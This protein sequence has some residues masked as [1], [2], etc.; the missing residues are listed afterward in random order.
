MD[1]FSRFFLFLGLFALL[2]FGFTKFSG[3]G[4]PAIQ[5]I[6]RAPLVLPSG[7][8][9]PEAT[10][11][12]WSDEYR[13]V[14]SSRG[15]VVKSLVPLVAK[16]RKGGSTLDLVTTPD[17]P[18][19]SP[20]FASFRSLKDPNPTNSSLVETDLQDFSIEETTATR[21]V[22]VHRS[23]AAEIRKTFSVGSGPYG[24]DLEVQLKNLATEPKSYAF[25]LSTSTYRKNADVQNGM[26][27]QNP[28]MTKVECFGKDGSAVREGPDAF[29]PDDFKDAEKFRGLDL[30][31]GDHRT[32]PGEASLAAISSAY[33]TT[34]MAPLVSP[35]EATCLLQIE[36]RWN[37]A[38][39]P[40]KGKDPNAAAIYRA[41]LAYSPKTLAPGAVDT[42]R[43]HAYIGPKERRALAESGDRF[44]ALIDLGFFSSVA[45]LLVS[46]LLFLYSVVKNWGLAIVLLTISAKLLLFP[47]TLP[48]LKNMIAMRELKPEMDKL[49]ERYKDDAQA[50]GLAQM[51]LWKKH[52]VNPM[53]GCWPQ[54]ASM[55]VWFAL[56]TTLQTA[57]ELYN[58]PFLWFPDLS[59]SDP[60]YILPFVIGGVFFLQQK[61][62]PMQGG[63][64][65]QQK[66]MMYM[67]PGMFTV[68]MLF[69]PAGLGVYMLT[70]SLLGI[71]Q[72]QV[73]EAHA[74][75]TLEAKKNQVEVL[76][77]PRSKKSV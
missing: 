26:F 51:E 32:F 13:A 24:I 6:R 61:L 49:N 54:L 68:F 5:P 27:R 35:T 42:F 28:M 66:M 75:K 67:M 65:A 34:A 30:H 31:V 59:E 47:L 76:G 33:F 72:Q 77:A 2:Y 18:E 15:G 12:L 41:R 7:E 57:V 14:L 22:F 25:S 62:T 63:D 39:F 73:V 1:R 29:E 36:E 40:D 64:P 71:V 11:D 9:T 37:S 16:Y 74:R 45:K 56:Y 44:D 20:L 17:H 60:Y 55:P 8:R 70:N 58:I 53:K 10:C 3:S 46:F 52:G 43:Y 69:L 38:S 4:E 19:L 21:C 48:S 50:K 23:G